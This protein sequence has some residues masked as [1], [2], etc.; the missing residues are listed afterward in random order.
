MLVPVCSPHDVEIAAEHDAV[1][2]VLLGHA[3]VDVVPVVT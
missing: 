1:A 2:L 3:V